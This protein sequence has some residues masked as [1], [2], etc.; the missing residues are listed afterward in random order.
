[1]WR[2]RAAGTSQTCPHC[3]SRAGTGSAASHPTCGLGQQLPLFTAPGT[4]R[5]S[6]PGRDEPV[7]PVLHRAKPGGMGRGQELS[8][9]GHSGCVWVA[10]G[11]WA[12]P[13]QRGCPHSTGAVL[14]LAGPQ[15]RCWPW[16]RAKPGASSGTEGEAALRAYPGLCVL[17]KCGEGAEGKVGKRAGW[18]LKMIKRPPR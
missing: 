7:F 11:R 3:V 16:E 4:H 17:L 14:L 5:W 18:H 10:E 9:A 15:L 1:M 2:R 13:G 6:Q 12:G 8:L